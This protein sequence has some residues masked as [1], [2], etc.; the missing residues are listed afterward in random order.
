MS[1]RHERSILARGLGGCL[2]SQHPVRLRSVG[3]SEL[4]SLGADWR[5]VGWASRSPPMW[6]RF[7]SQCHFCFS[8]QSASDSPLPD[9]S[10]RGLAGPAVVTY[11]LANAQADKRAADCARCSRLRLRPLGFGAHCS[12]SGCRVY[13]SFSTSALRRLEP[14]EPHSGRRFHRGA[15]DTRRRSDQDRRRG[16]PA[17]P[18]DAHSRRVDAFVFRHCRP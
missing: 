13:S 17:P 2:W 6:A 12:T 1:E 5:C 4:R 16:Q 9:V 3:S 14:G 7:S 11:R 15:P 18:L 10:D 8:A